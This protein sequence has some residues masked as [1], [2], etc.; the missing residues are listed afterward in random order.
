MTTRHVY[1]GRFAPFHK[2]HLRLILKLI[3]KVGRENILILIG[4]SNNVNKRTPFTFEDRAKI[5]KV[6]IPEIE[7]LPL[8]DGKAGVEYFDGSTN[9]MWLDSLEKLA[10]ERK[11]K[12]IFYGGSELDLE[13]LAQRF[14]T[15]LL[16]DRFEEGEG[17]SATK[18]RELIVNR[19]IKELE[20]FVESEA[21]DLIINNY[22]KV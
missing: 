17:L 1:L 13:I 5:I 6:S 22:Q 19:N 20:K 21:M 2:G 14:E 10:Q 4:S 8:P 12:F 7:I 18:I 15:R 3:A 9:D 16:I 11:E